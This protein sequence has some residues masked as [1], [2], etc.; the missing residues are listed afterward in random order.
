M[1]VH[2]ITVPYVNVIDFDWGF[3][4]TG[5][6]PWNQTVWS[7]LAVFTAV[8]LWMTVELTI[9]V[10]YVFRRWS[11]LYFWSVLICTWG[12]TLHT[13]GFIL[14]FCVPSCNW[15]V[16]TT[17]AEIGWV[18]MVT[19]FSVVL[20]SRLHLVVRSPR[21][22]NL[23]LIMVMTDAFL[24]HVPTIVFQYGI[25][26]NGK[27]HVYYL[28]F[29]APMERI[30]VFGFSIQ[31]VVISI[32]YI[33]ATLRMLKGSFNKKIRNTI[34]FLILIQIVAILVDVIVIALDYCEYFTLKAALHS[35]VFAFKLQLEF[36][37]L[38]QFKDVI[39]NGGI[40]PRGLEAMQAE[41]KNHLSPTP[42]RPANS[43]RKWGSFI[44]IGRVGT[45]ES[46]GK[47]EGSGSVTARGAT[48]KQPDVQV[49]LDSNQILPHMAGQ[50]DTLDIERQYLGAWDRSVKMEAG[51]RI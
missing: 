46:D 14:K 44:T 50:T 27:T 8:P 32:I 36:V 35:F 5:P 3:N 15:I 51:G 6:L 20:Y 37:I 39:A 29:M 30:Q 17:L 33:W 38:N 10:F 26:A 41:Q 11:G 48:P 25:S 43:P 18:S 40:A 31:E 16:S 45:V 22:L 49:R 13:I 19:G 23:V 12:V 47:T 34:I 4:R 1:S 9:W 21:I 28:P 7:I 2:N 42:A 24:F